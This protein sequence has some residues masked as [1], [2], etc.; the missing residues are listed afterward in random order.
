MSTQ[1]LD[2]LKTKSKNA[3]K[4]R[5]VNLS[6]LFITNKMDEA[7]QDKLYEMASG[8]L[9]PGGGD[10][11]PSFYGEDPHP[12][13]KNVDKEL[14]AMQLR[15]T[16]KTI[17]DKKPLLG[18][19]RGAQV[20][21]VAL[22]GKLIQHLPDITEE[23]H[24]VSIEQNDPVYPSS[25]F[26][27]VHIKPSTKAFEIF[28][29]DKISVP[30]RHHQSVGDPGELIISGHSPEGMPEIIEHPSLPFHFGLQTH[31]ELVNN[32]DAVFEAFGK[33]VKNWRR[34]MQTDQKIA[35]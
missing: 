28:Q 22:K 18:I 35:S 25:I 19:C 7:T 2:L 24:G 3:A 10:I 23:K 14:D 21:A 9:L 32:F 4:L 33:A 15:L 5:Q 1:Q 13:I 16:Q 26:H 29:S 31:P 30:S 27:D 6:P 17:Q 20:L 12:M 11:H 8:L 34:N